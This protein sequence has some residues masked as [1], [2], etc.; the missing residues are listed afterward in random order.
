MKNFIFSNVLQELVNNKISRNYLLNK[1]DD[2][3][4][5]SI[6]ENDEKNLK[7]VQ[8][9][10]FHFMDSM[11][12]S[13]VR[14]V[15]KGYFSKS[16]FKRLINVLVENSFLNRQNYS[17]KLE[18][19]KEKHGIYPPN[20]IVLSP[21][22]RCNLNC[23][24]CYASS[25][26]HATPTLPYHIVDK[27]V[28]DIRD[29]FHSRFVT[30]S[31]GEPFMYKSEGKTLLDLFEKYNDVFFLVYTNGTLIDAETAE[32]L[33]KTGNVT[34]AI[35]VE[36]FEHETDERRG[37]GTH[38][39]ILQAFEN[40]RNAGVPFGISVTATSKNQELLLTDKF[41][42]YYFD[43]QG[44]TYMWQFQL[45][46]MGRSN[47][48]FDLMVEPETRVE[49]YRKWEKLITEKKYCVADFWNSGVLVNGC[50]AYGKKNGYFYIDWNGNIM[51]CVFVPYYVD[52]V[53][54][55]YKNGKTLVDALFSD[56]MKNGRKWI[57]NYG[58]G[59]PKN[60]NNWLMPC[61]I[62]DHYANFRRNILPENARGESHEA[63]ESLNDEKYYKRLVHYDN[64]LADLTED[65][66]N[67]EYL[68]KKEEE[69]KQD[70]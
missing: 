53:Y 20:F 45:M 25:N 27:I 17:D 9:K 44:A 66:W 14:N 63:D 10:K 38:N 2:Y 42:D 4:Y 48:D 18:D 5:K 60:P 64:K 69:V 34:P 39:K 47:Q 19:F 28:G 65:I 52:N 50:I 33:S 24:G 58:E 70:S 40:L 31:G 32:R 23:T 54:E 36:G 37:K 62:R 57:H 35:S 11:L 8:E 13:A 15:D 3:M 49:L 41:Y 51:P 26:A 55:L 59:H 12:K 22:Q 29:K 21:T 16:V 7:E 1:L 6:V 61:S 46:P 67:K 43:E 68:K 30:I 56:F